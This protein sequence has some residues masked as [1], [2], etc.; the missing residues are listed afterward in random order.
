MEKTTEPLYKKIG[1][2]Y[3][4]VRAK[5][6]EENNSDQM[7][8]GSFRLTYAYADG[9]RRY[10]YDVIPSTAPVVAAMLIA[11]TAMEDA[12][13]EASKMHPIKSTKPYSKNQIKAIERFKIEMGGMMP[14]WWTENSSSEIA[15]AAIKAVLNYKP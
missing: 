5:W 1:R 15:N 11:K 9:G 7:K 12:I 13:H 10:E 2:K 3:V 14:L 8:T 6:Y 4:P